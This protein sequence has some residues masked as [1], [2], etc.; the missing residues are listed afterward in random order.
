[1]QVKRT[2]LYAMQQAVDILNK[3]KVAVEKAEPKAGPKAE[4]K[5]E[6]KAGV[7]REERM[8]RRRMCAKS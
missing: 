7:G 2:T 8:E 5:A 4:P 6:P 3:K 1:M